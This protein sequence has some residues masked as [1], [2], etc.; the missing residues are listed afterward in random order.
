MKIE[1][2]CSFEGTWSPGFEIA[3]VMLGNDD[4]VGYRL[5]RM[6]DG[7]ILPAVFPVEDII[8]AGR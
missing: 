5:R 1:V 6:S 4:V 7:A 8:P 2:R 3:E